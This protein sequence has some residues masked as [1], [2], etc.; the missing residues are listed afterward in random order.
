VATRIAIIGGFMGAGKTALVNRIARVLNADGRTVGLIVND[1]GEVL[2]DTQY[3]R[4]MGYE[5]SE[6][7]QGSLGCRYDDL[8]SSA[9]DLVTRTRPDIIIVEP[10]GSSTDLLATVVAPL[11]TLYPDEFEVAPLIIVVDA[12]RLVQEGSDPTTLGGYL[13]KYQIE[14]AEHIVI[15]KIDMV[16]R[17]VLLELVDAVQ[18]LN[19]QAEVI[20]YSAITGHGLD[21]IMD[22]VRSG[23]RSDRLP[24]EIDHDT[25]ARAEAEIAWYDGSFSFQTKER[26]D[27]H[28]L[29]TTILRA[30]SFYYDPSEIAH[31]KLILT[32]DSDS[33]KMSAVFNNIAVDMIKGSRYAEGKVAVII[34]VRAISGIE[35]L[36]ANIRLSV[37]EAMES[38]RQQIEGFK[39]ECFSSPR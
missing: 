20:P 25:Y 19:P 27:A 8:I 28:D 2:V 24:V 9:R 35:E 31:A 17:N 3:L 18:S 36:R 7:L 6:V 30:I 39:D 38:M 32:S 11:K 33:L 26:L 22:I 13:R 23:K 34:N 21:K 12:S 10:V 5:T 1:Q 14:E 37:F 16:T 29:A 15:S 4:A